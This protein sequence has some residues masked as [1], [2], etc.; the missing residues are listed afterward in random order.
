M[1]LLSLLAPALLALAAPLAAQ[2]RVGVVEIFG[3]HKVPR[4]RLLRALAVSPGDPLPPSRFA[5][6]QRLEALDGVISAKLEA[7]CCEAGKAVLYVGILERGTPLFEKRPEPD[8]DLALPDEIISAYADFSSALSR[9]SAENDLAEDLS[10]GHSLMTSV[11]CLVAQK[12]FLGLASLHLETLRAVLKSAREPDQ[13]AIAA[14]VVGY[15]PEK[16]PIVADLQLA[17]RDP[18][19]GVRANA[20]R[21]LRALASASLRNPDIGW[22]VEPTWFVEMLNSIDLSDRLE[23]TRALLPYTE[24]PAP[25]L[26]ASLRERAL[27]ALLEM[28]RWQHLPHALQAYLLAGR[29][30][31][32]PD[33]ELEAAWA[34]GNRESILISIEKPPR[35]K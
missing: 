17:L 32:L 24:K 5:V 1:H 12:R 33:A 20:A 28:A 25:G 30:A 9:A 4:E 18:D 3:A 31:A 34:A 6:E 7:F 29:V 13:R 10:A 26:L 23:A 21:A 8:Q 35:K 11:A 15:A 16:A 19:P 14:Y 22:R 27:P 2:P